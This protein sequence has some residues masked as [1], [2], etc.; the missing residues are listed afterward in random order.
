MGYQTVN[1]YDNE[2]VAAFDDLTDE[3]AMQLLAQGQKT[4]ESWGQARLANARRYAGGPPPSFATPGRV[5][6]LLTLEM[7]KL[8]A[9]S[10]GEVELSAQIF[11]YYAE[12]A[13]AFLAPERFNRV[14]ADDDAMV[15]SAPIGVILGIQPWNFPFYQLARVAAPNLMAGNVVMVNAPPTCPRRRPPSSSCCWKPVAQRR[16]HQPVCDQG[17]ALAAD[18]RP[19]GARSVVDRKRGCRHHRRAGG[20]EPQEVHHGAGGFGGA[21]RVGR[22]RRDKTVGWARQGR[23]FNGGQC[24]VASKRIIVAEEIADEF[25]DRFQADCRARKPA[26]RSTRQ[27]RC[28]RCPPRAPPTIVRKINAAVEAGAKAVPWVSRCLPR[29]HSCSPRS[30]PTSPGQPGLLP[31]VLWTCGAVLPRHQAED[32]AVQLA[33]DSRYRAGRFSVHGRPRAWGR[34]GQADRDRH[35]V[36]QPPHAGSRPTYRSAAIKLSG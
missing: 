20:Q 30:L 28:P 33:N 9:E 21:D 1:P 35:G 31:G 19:A 13:E 29:A 7:G 8:Y 3:E 22:R 2:V 4:F 17:S 11:E 24:C 36:H 25:L 15:V 6:R 23:I 5:R 27:P 34:G 16:L 32:D 12:N 18:R 26:T 14:S 10:L